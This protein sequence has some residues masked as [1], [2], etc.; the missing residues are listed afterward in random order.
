MGVQ[1][2]QTPS[3]FLNMP[4]KTPFLRALACAGKVP[5]RTPPPGKFAF[6]AALGP[7]ELLTGRAGIL[8]TTLTPLK[9]AQNEPLSARTPSTC[10]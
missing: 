9:R 8:F 10:T 7:G 3:R 4:K 1:A 2:C 5:P 6:G